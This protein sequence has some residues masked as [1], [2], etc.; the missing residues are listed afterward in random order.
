MYFNFVCVFN[1][2]AHVQVSQYGSRGWRV[3]MKILAALSTIVRYFSRRDEFWSAASTAGKKIGFS[4]KSHR[5][6]VRIV[7][8]YNHQAGYL[9]SCPVHRAQGSER[10]DVGRVGRASDRRRRTKRANK[11]GRRAR[12]PPGTSESLK[13]EGIIP[14]KP[15]DSIKLA[16]LMFKGQFQRRAAGCKGDVTYY[17]ISHPSP[18]SD[19]EAG[20]SPGAISPVISHLSHPPYV[21]RKTSRML[22]TRLRTSCMGVI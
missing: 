7:V 4:Q 8:V 5:G 12:I 14:L 1:P 6:G 2:R 11:K 19:P 3:T 10:V 21:S 20:F 15:R 16:E 18:S 13:V 17:R 22:C 9:H